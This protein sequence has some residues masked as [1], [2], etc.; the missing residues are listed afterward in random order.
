MLECK[1][2]YF[3][4]GIEYVLCNKEKKPEKTTLKECAKAMCLYQRYCPQVRACAL[5]PEWRE[6]NKITEKVAVE[7]APIEEKPR[8]ATKAKIA[9]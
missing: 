2:A 5:K 1:H 9:E 6:C 3:M 7:E 4:D 8:K